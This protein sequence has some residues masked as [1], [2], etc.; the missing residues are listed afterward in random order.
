M[1]PSARPLHP[2]PRYILSASSQPSP[3]HADA[4]TRPQVHTPPSVGSN[5]GRYFP[6]RPRPQAAL[7]E[8]ACV[9]ADVL[10]YKPASD[11]ECLYRRL[12]PSLPISAQA[13]AVVDRTRTAKMVGSPGEDGRYE[14]QAGCSRTEGGER[15]GAG[16]RRRLAL[17]LRLRDR[18]VAGLPTGYRYRSW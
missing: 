17:L 13:T 5:P 8:T 6:R 15:F 3:L 14:Y 12:G 1:A 18:H 7:N 10:L 16:F 2:T 9:S 4:A 11:T